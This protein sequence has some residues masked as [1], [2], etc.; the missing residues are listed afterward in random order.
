MNQKS[1]IFL[2][3]FL[4]FFSFCS[5][6][7]ENPKNASDP[8]NTTSEISGEWTCIGYV[9]NID[10][11]TPEREIPQESLFLKGIELKTNDTAVWIFGENCSVTTQW[12]GKTIVSVLDQPAAYQLK[13]INDQ[14]YLFVEWISD[15]VTVL[16]R[17]PCWYVCKIADT[18]TETS[19]IG[20]WVT[21]D[22]VET[23]EQFDPRQRQWSGQPFL[24]GLAFL[25]NGTVW[26]IFEENQRQKMLW[27]GNA[28]DYRSEY[29]AHFTIK[30]ID[31]NAYLFFEWISGDVTIRG[32]E[33]AY[34][35]LK[36]SE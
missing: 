8:N 23:I 6:A 30:R 31:G 35:V 36:K 33:P 2:I 11:F 9:E 29:P 20:R 22:F 28:V 26:Q 24:R 1:C 34:Y 17:K 16:N 13:S 10:D 4:L 12:D 7:A 19:P 18:L 27:R 32:Q 5:F 21:V 15:D 3:V 14:T 25:K